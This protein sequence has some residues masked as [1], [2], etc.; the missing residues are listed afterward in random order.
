LFDYIAS[1]SGTD[2]AEA[3]L[4]RIERTVSILSDLPL[5]GR[6]HSELEGT[7]RTFA[8]WPWILIYEPDPGGKGIVLWRVLD[9]RRDLPK[10]VRPPRPRR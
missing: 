3:V 7:P 2:R 4:R 8:I 10:L 5:I 1:E 9:G 6:A